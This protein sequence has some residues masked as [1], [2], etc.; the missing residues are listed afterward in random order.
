MASRDGLPPVMRQGLSVRVVPPALQGP[1]SL[2]VK[3]VSESGSGEL[4]G[5]DGIE[6]LT[7]SRALVGKTL[8]VAQKD[9]PHDFILRDTES[10]IGRSVADVNLG[11][12]GSIVAVSSSVAQDV[13]HIRYGESEILF[14]AAD[15]LIVE[16]GQT[17]PLVIRLPHG[18]IDKEPDNA[19]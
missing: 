2:V 6:N 18:I 11:E 4:V 3:T 14:P 9:L 7:E 16:F 13:W 1:R 10:L 12:L 15:E 5:F 19:H 8:L 17:D